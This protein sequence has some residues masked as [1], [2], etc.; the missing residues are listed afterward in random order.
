MRA[1]PRRRG[2]ATD[3]PCKAVRAHNSWRFRGVRVVCQG[4]GSPREQARQSG[5]PLASR[6]DNPA[7]LWRPGPTSGEPLAKRI[8][9]QASPASDQVFAVHV[10]EN[11]GKL[12]QEAGAGEGERLFVCVIRSLWLRVPE[13][14]WDFWN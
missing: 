14:C 6:L 13:Q 12:L 8:N 3:V 1:A 9:T 5:E 4:R 2:C 11:A 7:S 10:L